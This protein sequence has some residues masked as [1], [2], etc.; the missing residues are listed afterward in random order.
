MAIFLRP[1]VERGC[2]LSHVASSKG[3]HS[4]KSSTLVPGPQADHAYHFNGHRKQRYCPVEKGTSGQP[5]NY[6]S[7][8]SPP[9]TIPFV[10]RVSTHAFGGGHRHS[11]PSKEGEPLPG[12]C[13]WVRGYREIPGR[14]G[15][16]TLPSARGR[17]WDRDGGG[18]LLRTLISVMW[19]P[20]APPPTAHGR[21]VHP[22]LFVTSSLR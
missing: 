4:I 13:Q 2:K 6:L 18:G 7:K 3:T 8:A 10:M 21:R 9:S 15:R 5:S 1:H 16:R 17:R 20:C 19:G 11:V 22:V 14:P 12:P